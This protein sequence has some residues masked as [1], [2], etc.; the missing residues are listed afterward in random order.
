M[1]DLFSSSFK[2]YSDLKQQVHFDD[3]EA[4]GEAG[5]ETMNL[6]KFFEDVDNVKDDMRVVEQLY[7]GL[8][9]SNEKTKSCSQC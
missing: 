7:N 6:D 9:E 3:L 5:K 2:K 4:A 1:N 8:R